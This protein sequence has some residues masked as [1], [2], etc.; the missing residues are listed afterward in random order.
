MATKAYQVLV[1]KGPECGGKRFAGDIAALFQKQLKARGLEGR[2]RLDRYCC[3]GRCQSG[4]NVLTREAPDQPELYAVTGPGSKM[5]PGVGPA[6]VAR[7]IDALLAQDE[8]LAPDGPA[9]A[10]ALPAG[11]GR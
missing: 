6:D 7:I 4:P 1:C 2:I 11:A 9:V 3:F 10:A 8:D 5:H